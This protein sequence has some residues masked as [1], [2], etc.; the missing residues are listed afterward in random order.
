MSKKPI[1]EVGGRYCESAEA[2][3]YVS[4][5]IAALPLT[6]KSKEQNTMKDRKYYE[7]LFTDYPDLLTLEQFREMLGGM[8]DNIARKLMRENAVKHFYIRY[9]YFIPKCCA[10]DY[11]LSEEYAELKK[12]LKNV[13]N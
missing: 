2:M 4:C 9:T 12:T 6:N 11:A 1:L 8:S 10:I 3:E 13:L 5:G 7:E